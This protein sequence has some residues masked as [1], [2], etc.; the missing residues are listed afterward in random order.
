MLEEGVRAGAF[1]RTSTSSWVYRFIRDTVWVAVHWYRPG[2]QLSAQDGRAV[3]RHPARR[4][5]DPPA[6][7]PSTLIRR[8]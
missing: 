4:H 1:G 5:L 7:G 6:A 2:G 8:P 3:S